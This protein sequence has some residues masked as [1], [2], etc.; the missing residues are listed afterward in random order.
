[1]LSKD[2]L[3]QFTVLSKN[4]FLLQFSKEPTATQRLTGQGV[5]GEIVR[6][7]TQDF[8]KNQKLIFRAFVDQVTQIDRR[9]PAQRT[10]DLTLAVELRS[11]LQPTAP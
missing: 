9:S 4:Y 10:I 11:R 2:A 5:V 6:R 1:M 7:F 8:N 3:S